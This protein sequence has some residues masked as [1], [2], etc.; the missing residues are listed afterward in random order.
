MDKPRGTDYLFIALGLGALYL[1]YQA[2]QGVKAAGA[3][4]TDAAGNAYHAT[5]AAL[6]TTGESIGGAVFDFLHPPDA[7]GQVFY[8]VTFDDT[9]A[10][11][12]VD[13]ADVSV[14]GSFNWSDGVTRVLYNDASNAHRAKPL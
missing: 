1:V 5:S 10:R 8:V 2:V 6:T 13:A 4:I 12:A 14:D 9:G 11:H 3:A 7:H